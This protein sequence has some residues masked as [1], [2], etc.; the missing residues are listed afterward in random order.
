VET[1]EQGNLEYYFFKEHK[2]SL[3]FAGKRQE[4]NIRKSNLEDVFITLTDTRV[5]DGN[6]I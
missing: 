1:Y 6:E 2:E 4:V 3:E 5:G